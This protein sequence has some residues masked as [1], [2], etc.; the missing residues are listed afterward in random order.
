[1]GSIAGAAGVNATAN[2]AF[3]R[4]HSSLVPLNSTPPTTYNNTD[5]IVEW[6]LDGGLTDSSGNGYNIVTTNGSAV[7]SSTPY[8]GTFAR[9]QVKPTTWSDWTS[10]RAG[11]AEMLTG[12]NSYS[13]ADSSNTATCLWN[14][15]TYPA[16]AGPPTFSSHSTCDPAVSGTIKGPYTFSLKAT[17]ADGNIGTATIDVG[18]VVTDSNGIVIQVD[19]AADDIFGP[20]IAFGSNPWAY[21][22]DT[23][24]RALTIRG[25]NAYAAA[26]SKDWLTYKT[27]TVA[28]KANPYVSNLTTL[29]VGINA[30]D[31]T[32]VV[33]STASLNLTSYPTIIQFG[34]GGERVLICSN[35][36][37]TLTVCPD[38]RGW[39]NTTAAAHTSGVGIV[40]PIAVGTGTSILSDYCSGRIGPFTGTGNYTTGTAAATTGSTTLTG[41]GTTWSGNVF[42]GQTVRFSGIISAVAFEFITT[43]ASV[44]GNTTITLSRAYPASAT[45]VSGVTYQI[46]NANAFFTPR[47]D[48]PDATNGHIRY[49]D[50]SCI[51][52]TQLTFGGGL[53]SWTGTQSGQQHSMSTQ[54]WMTQGG[55]GTPNFYDEV[56]A[57]IAMYLRSGYQAALDAARWLG[58]AWASSPEMDEGWGFGPGIP[59]NV[60]A[61]GI[62]AS[63]KV[64]NRDWSYAMNKLAK[65]A[66]A[67][68][69][70]YGTNC[71]VGDLRED[72]Y[73]FMWLAMAAKYD[74]DADQR[75][76][77]LASL[78]T[79]LTREEACQEASGYYPSYNYYN[80]FTPA[81]TLTNGL[82]TGTGTGFTNN[83]CESI[84]TGTGSVTNGS[85][86][87]T[88]T[89]IPAVSGVQSISV[90]G[91]RS[92]QPFS[93]QGGWS[94]S[95]S[96]VTLSGLWAG[97]SGSVTWITHSDQNHTMFAD[98]QTD[99]QF[100]VANPCIYN[101]STSITLAKP[102]GGTTG[103]KNWYRGNLVGAGMQP[104]MGGIKALEYY[105][106]K[107]AT[108]G[109][110]QTAYTTLGTEIAGWI[111][112]TGYDSRSK[113]LFYGRGFGA[114]EPPV[115]PPGFDQSTFTSSPAFDYSVSGCQYG[116]GLGAVS[117][118]RALN[119]EAQNA[120]RLVYEADPTTPN[121]DFGDN[122]YC[123][124][125]G[126]AALTT[127]G[128]CTNNG[129]ANDYA[130]NSALSAG[131]WY[132]F[133]F[134][135]G[136][137]HQWPAVRLG[138]VTPRTDVAKPIMARLAD[139]SGAVDIVVDY[140]AATGLVSQ[141]SPCTVAACTFDT[142]ARQNYQYRVRYRNGSAVTLATGQYVPVR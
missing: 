34:Y 125:W 135:V 101:S 62:L 43:I 10:L 86:T 45:N 24:L 124:Q 123:A 66:Q 111:K 3:F 105:F 109:A 133:Q 28:Y 127:G 129:F 102:W 9:P 44:G 36:T 98:S 22:D 50:A 58:D 2:V 21:A 91:L 116:F 100:N 55:N 126:D 90:S 120:L 6:K 7:Y 81:V 63:W 131:K 136:M 110:T 18:A 15:L 61:L 52:D 119:S 49:S 32:I 23:A 77:F 41:S 26:Y 89:S 8:Q 79:L 99:T 16:I 122:F 121:R 71:L 40:Q 132:G 65:N 70:S 25:A 51:S 42:A 74:P 137:A 56:A 64:D 87:M 113:G 13:Q 96:S 104:F 95:G 80:L 53:E 20:M 67:Y 139:V 69:T 118:A 47:W 57:H 97:T 68:V 38:G 93:W 48:R 17:G 4:L 46:Y 130:T 31:T 112:D 138:G 59:R 83:F 84:A 33:A 94:G 117:A 60:G 37:V 115:N 73:Q 103:A 14:A 140:M 29:A 128:L 12:S 108:T 76:S 106:A 39:S 107:L 1:M 27:G 30:T 88:G 82:K 5:R 114:C 75:T 78:A 11:V 19:S 35:V 141:S 134:G 85:A 142:D 92:G 72:A 54:T